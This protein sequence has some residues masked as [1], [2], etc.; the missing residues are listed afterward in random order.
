MRYDPSVSL[1]AAAGDDSPESLTALGA[2]MHPG[3]TMLAVQTGEISLPQGAVVMS[4]LPLV[5]MTLETTISEVE[6]PRIVPLDWPDAQ[7]M[8]DLASLAKP[9]PFGLKALAFGRFSGIKIDGQ[10]V[11]MA[12]ERLKLTG[13]T[14]LSGVCVH[15]DFR[16][17]GY[18]RLLSLFASGRTVAAGEKPFLH[19]Y[20]GNS[21]AISLYESIGFRIRTDLTAAMIAPAA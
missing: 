13:F 12:G 18:A 4:S 9:G 14:E 19:C 20:A 21:Q 8:F 11:A 2:L 15:P 3:E 5:Q 10:L 16:G 17:K 6:D 7:A 1:F